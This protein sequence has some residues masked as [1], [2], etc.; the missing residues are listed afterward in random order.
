[1]FFFFYLGYLS[2]YLRIKGL[3]GKG[4]GISLTSHYHFHPLHRHLD[5][6]LAIT[7]EGSP[8]H[9]VAAGLESGT[10]GFPAQVAN[11]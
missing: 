7:A 11:H 9:I 3:Q 8:P 10:F 4:E 5:I 2:H 6:S 1:M